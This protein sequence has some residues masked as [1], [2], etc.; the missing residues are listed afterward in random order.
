MSS[1]E[2]KFSA[3]LAVPLTRESSEEDMDKAFHDDDDEDD[4][5]EEDEEA[6]SV[7]DDVCGKD[8]KGVE[9]P[10]A[11]PVRDRGERRK[12]AAATSVFLLLSL[13]LPL[14]LFLRFLL[15]LLSFLA[16]SILAIYVV[17]KTKDE[18]ERCA[19][20]AVHWNVLCPL[21][22]RSVLPK[23]MT[24]PVLAFYFLHS[25]DGAPSS[26]SCD[27][28]P[29]LTRPRQCRRSPNI[30]RGSLALIVSPF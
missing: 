14:L 17:A 16:A 13:P 18:T 8:K 1:S 12:A 9:E 23:K 19:A 22:H 3:V 7:G 29:L 28:P 27:R 2:P 11:E 20:S 15:L 10:E 4:E 26:D 30:S 6:D 5:E 25:K 21:Q 24:R